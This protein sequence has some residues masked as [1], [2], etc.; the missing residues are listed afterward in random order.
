MCRMTLPTVDE[1]YESC[2]TKKT[3]YIIKPTTSFTSCCCMYLFE[4]STH[5]LI[6]QLSANFHRGAHPE[7]GEGEVNRGAD[8]GVGGGL[9]GGLQRE[10][11]NELCSI[12]D[13]DY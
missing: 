6:L 12:S 11:K 3:T 5:E 10:K 1:L 7:I 4:K 2:V 8:G 13:Y 9:G